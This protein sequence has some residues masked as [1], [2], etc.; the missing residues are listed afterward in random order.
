MQKIL[1]LRLSNPIHFDRGCRIQKILIKA[2]L[3]HPKVLSATIR[4]RKNSQ[5]CGGA[6]S[7]GLTEAGTEAGTA[8]NFDF[9]LFWSAQDTSLLVDAKITA[10]ASAGVDKIRQNTTANGDPALYWRRS[11]ARCG[12]WPIRSKR[13]CI[14]DLESKGFRSSLSECKIFSILC[15]SNLKDFDQGCQNPK[16]YASKTIR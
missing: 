2:G 1:H 16:H 3:T 11:T 9:A 12:A 8:Q 15:V 10:R 6:A 7:S 5:K 4:Y 13:F 14:W